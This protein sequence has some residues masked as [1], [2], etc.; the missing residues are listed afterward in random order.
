MRFLFYPSLA[1][2]ATK[3]LKKTPPD[4]LAGSHDQA[5]SRINICTK[6]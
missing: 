6:D 4:W 3:N 2:Q 1:G 5:L